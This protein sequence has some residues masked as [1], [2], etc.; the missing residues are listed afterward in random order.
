VGLL[1][2][3]LETINDA[4]R[5]GPVV[6]RIRPSNLSKERSVSGGPGWC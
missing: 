2:R 4:N 5:D 3:Y 1:S 6:E